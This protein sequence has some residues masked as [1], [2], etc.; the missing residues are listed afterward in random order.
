MIGLKGSAG[1]MRRGCPTS[2]CEDRV[3]H[4]R[5][6]TLCE[7]RRPAEGV[8]ASRAMASGRGDRPSAHRCRAGHTGDDA[9]H[10]RLH[11]RGQVAPPRRFPPAASLPIPAQAARLQQ[12]TAQERRTASAYHPA[13]GHRYLGVE[14]RRV[15]RGLHT[16][17][18]WPF[19][20]DRQTFRPGRM[21]RVRVLRQ[22][23]PLL[24]GPAAAPGVHPPGPARRLRPD[25]SKG[26]RARDPAGPP[27][28]RTRPRRR[29]ARPL[30]PARSGS[31]GSR[32][33]VFT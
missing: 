13:A 33:S 27:R 7:D 22:S 30:R 14:R 8:S 1:L 4:S 16:G 24:L 21:G 3:G 29:P 15:D 19:T 10:A 23:Q 5:N 9:G 31:P 32:S 18:M 28:R 6:R 11:L 12:A 17:G 20:R 2:V 25:R 26:R